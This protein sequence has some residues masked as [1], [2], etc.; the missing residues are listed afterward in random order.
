[1]SDWIEKQAL[2]SA[3]HLSD[4]IYKVVLSDMAVAFGRGHHAA[5]EEMREGQRLLLAECAEAAS[6]QSR[7]VEALRAECEAAYR[8]ALCGGIDDK[9][10]FYTARAN[11]LRVDGE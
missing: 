7:L 2:A 11:R 5:V 1:M 6:K 8:Y 9:T 3:K 4:E 10:N